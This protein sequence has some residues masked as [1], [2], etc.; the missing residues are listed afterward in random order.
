MWCSV[1]MVVQPT[2]ARTAKMK[3]NRVVD[4]ME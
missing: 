2:N 4:S 1:L 3:D